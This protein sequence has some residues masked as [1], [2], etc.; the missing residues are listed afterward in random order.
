MSTAELNGIKLNLISWINQLSDKELISFLDGIRLS[1][2]NEDWWNELSTVQKKQ[3]LSG[4][5]DAD[6]GKVIDSKDFW[7][8]IKNV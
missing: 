3:I 5:K 2:A 8:K 6:E 1:R 4:I 7:K